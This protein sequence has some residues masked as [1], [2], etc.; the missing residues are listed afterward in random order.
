MTAIPPT[1]VNDSSTVHAKVTQAMVDV[2]L[3]IFHTP[4][5]GLFVWAKLPTNP[6]DSIEVAH[7]ALAKRI[8]LAPGSYFRPGD[9][10]SEWF[11]FNAATADV[12]ELWTF[13][14]ELSGRAR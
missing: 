5:A 1:S 14:K 7:Q 9:P 13:M 11:R 10:A 8:W 3:E 4:H 12:P 6:E 2:G